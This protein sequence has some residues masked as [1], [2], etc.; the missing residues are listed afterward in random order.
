MLELSK[1]RDFA[2]LTSLAALRTEQGRPA[3]SLA[4]LEQAIAIGAP[5]SPSA[6]KE[7][8]LAQHDAG[9]ALVQ[10]GRHE[11]AV[12][13]FKAVTDADPTAEASWSALGVCL[14]ELGQ[15][16]AA[17]TCQRQVLRLRAEATNSADRNARQ[18][19]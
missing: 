4:L 19:G 7:D 12:L 11:D 10:L 13:I 2:A 1:R 17:L 18:D 6:A 14:T 9:M 8:L 15:L 5:P 16:E 3:D